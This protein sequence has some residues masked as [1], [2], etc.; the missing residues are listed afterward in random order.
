MLK[1]QQ[2]G[3]H[4]LSKFCE[5]LLNWKALMSAVYVSAYNYDNIL[6]S[7][8]YRVLCHLWRNQ[9]CDVARHWGLEFL[10]LNSQQ[11][12]AKEPKETK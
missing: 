7:P 5:M 10:V 11:L 1:R 6:L 3:K 2:G 12:Y 4:I 9:N 8:V